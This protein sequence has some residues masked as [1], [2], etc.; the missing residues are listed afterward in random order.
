MATIVEGLQ[1]R[2][3]EHLG[4]GLTPVVSFTHDVDESQKRGENAD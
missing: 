3:D 2:G 4:R 1:L